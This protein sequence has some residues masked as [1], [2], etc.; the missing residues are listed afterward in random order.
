LCK[1]QFLGELFSSP[2]VVDDKIVVGCR[3]DNVYCVDLIANS[4][5]N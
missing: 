4:V 2:V 1:Y 5:L 3:D